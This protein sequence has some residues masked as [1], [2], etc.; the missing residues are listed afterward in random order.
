M[1]K[2]LR[3]GRD[4]TQPILNLGTKKGWVVNTITWPC[5]SQESDLLAIVQEAGWAQRISPRWG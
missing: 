5:Y 1:Q 3:G 2:S 4:I